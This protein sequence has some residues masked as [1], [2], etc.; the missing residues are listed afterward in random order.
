MTVE[1][2]VRFPYNMNEHT[3]NSYEMFWLPLPDFFHVKVIKDTVKVFP[4]A[5]EITLLK[6]Y[7]TQTHLYMWFRMDAQNL[8][9][10]C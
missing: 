3:S 6:C 4:K 1:K 10:I 5:P 8:I 9:A 2:G 7:G